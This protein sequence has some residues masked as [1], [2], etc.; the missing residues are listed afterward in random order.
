MAGTKLYSIDMFVIK[1]YTY[2]RDEEP[3]AGRVMSENM[4]RRI[5]HAF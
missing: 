4:N 1:G 3:M 5:T 2:S